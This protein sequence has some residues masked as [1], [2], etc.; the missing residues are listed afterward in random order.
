M[1]IQK[2]LSDPSVHNFT[3]DILEK[4]GQLD[5]VDALEDLML[6]AV[7]WKGEVDRIMGNHQEC[8]T[9]ASCRSCSKEQRAACQRAAEVAEVFREKLGGN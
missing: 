4:C 7:T 8:L 1:E 3:K 6:A 5:P 9:S 2:I